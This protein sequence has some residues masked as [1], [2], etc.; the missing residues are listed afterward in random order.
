[1]RGQRILT[2]KGC[3]NCHSLN[4]QGGA[5]G[6]DL[7]VPSKS[8]GTPAL[9]ATSVWNHMPAM[10]SEIENSKAPPPVLEPA[11]AADLFAYF[12]STFYFSPRGNAARGRNVFIEKQG[13]SC[14]SEILNTNRR[15]S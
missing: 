12:Y 11:E 1:V 14:H 15:P 8:A 5:R 3:L 10:L 7:G 13:S 4:G 9:F 2:A 6:P